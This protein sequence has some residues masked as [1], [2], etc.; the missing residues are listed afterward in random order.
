MLISQEII[1][2]LTEDAAE[3]QRLM[4]EIAAKMVLGGMVT[5]TFLATLA[6]GLLAPLMH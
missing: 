2:G 5:T 4:N 6:A 1:E 3:R